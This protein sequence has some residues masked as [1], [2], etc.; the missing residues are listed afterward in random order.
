MGSR[1]E[2]VF[3]FEQLLKHIKNENPENVYAKMATDP[4]IDLDTTNSLTPPDVAYD[5]WIKSNLEW[6]PVTENWEK[7]GRNEV[8]YWVRHYLVRMEVVNE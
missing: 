2:R 5:N 1:D 4:R 7:Y 3:Y 6:Y 8:A